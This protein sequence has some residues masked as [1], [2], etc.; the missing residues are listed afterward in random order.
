MIL[1]VAH[2]SMNLHGLTMHK[3]FSRSEPARRQPSLP[4][5]WSWVPKDDQPNFLGAL[6]PDTSFRGYSKPRPHYYVTTP[7]RLV[8]PYVFFILFRPTRDGGCAVFEYLGHVT[9]ITFN[10]FNIYGSP[11]VTNYSVAC[12]Y[13]ETSGRQYTLESQ[14]RARPN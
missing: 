7:C 9:D 2:V 3:A 1:H 11:V 12:Y 10:L 13:Y 8:V 5:R 4:Q 14:K 6:S